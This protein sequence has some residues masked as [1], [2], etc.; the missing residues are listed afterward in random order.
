[1]SIEK[2]LDTAVEKALELFK[3]PPTKEGE[4]QRPAGSDI[5]GPVAQ[6]LS[7]FRALAGTPELVNGGAWVGL[8]WAARAGQDDFEAAMRGMAK[9]AVDL[10]PLAS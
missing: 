1:M 3:N 6:F 10:H 2:D 8:V 5:E 4:A 9:R 7:D